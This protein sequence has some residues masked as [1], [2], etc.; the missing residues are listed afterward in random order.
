MKSKFEVFM[1]WCGR[2]HSNFR[3]AY[4]SEICMEELWQTK[5]NLLQ[6]FQSP[7]PSRT[8]TQ[9]LREFHAGS[10]QNL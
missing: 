1:K 3:Y 9:Y 8:H 2:M 6:D 5:E 7:D 4:Y 10:T